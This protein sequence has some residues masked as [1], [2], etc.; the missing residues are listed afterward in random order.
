MSEAIISSA[1]RS[2]RLKGLTSNNVAYRIRFAND[3][4]EEIRRKGIKIKVQE[5]IREILPQR[6]KKYKNPI[7]VTQ[8]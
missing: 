5:L 4:T 3:I 8:L 6:K 1:S 2:P 7:D